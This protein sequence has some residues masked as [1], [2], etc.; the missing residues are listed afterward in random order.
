MSLMLDN[1]QSVTKQLYAAANGRN[2]CSLKFADEDG[3]RRVNPHGIFMSK[4]KNLIIV[5][6][7]SSGFSS[8][9]NSEGYKNLSLEKCETVM[10][11]NKKFVK[12]RDF[13]PK[14]EQYGEWLFHI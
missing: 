13:N 4:Q 7:Q 8:K 6:W 11:L 10:V 3:Y 2:I 9:G 14:D 12:R 5:G 1:L